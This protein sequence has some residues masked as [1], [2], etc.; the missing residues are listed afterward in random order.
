M[1][2]SVKHAT[3][4]GAGTM[5]A[6][7]A[8]H[9]ANAGI[10]VYLLDIIPPELTEKERLEGVDLKDPMVRN[11]LAR[12]GLARVM[13]SPAA[14]FS[15]PEL[16]DKVKVGN[17]EDDL[18][19]IGVSDLVIEAVVEDMEIKQALMKR[20]EVIRQS[21]SIVTTNTSGLPIKD[22]A[23]ETSDEFARH[24][25]GTH[26]FNPPP[27]M[28]LLEII[29]GPR[30]EPAVLEFM[31]GFCGEVLGKGVVVCKD[32]PNFIANRI[33]AIQRS[34]DMEYVLEEGY[35]VEE[36]DAILGRVIGRPKTAL[37]R[38]GDLVGIDVSTKV[39]KN[40]YALIPH[41]EYRELLVGPLSVDL[42]KRMIE[43]NL[44]GRKTG[45]G[46]YKRVASPEGT[47]FLGLDLAKLEY[48]EPVMQQ[49]PRLEQASNIDDL[50]ERI[51]FL[52]SED[53]RLGRLVWA[54]L[55]NVLLYSAYSTPEISDNLISVDRAMRWGYSWDLGPFELWDLLGVEAIVQRMEAED[56]TVA[57]WV[58]KMLDAGNTHFYKIENGQRWQFSPASLD[59]EI[60]QGS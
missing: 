47:Q 13:A 24:F 46:F 9:L 28:K 52:I 57:M 3:V 19:L 40:L 44:L 14:G 55:S 29:P 31:I 48:R 41:D 20:V 35:S 53:D 25:L 54:S 56:Q 8:A 42:R 58:R 18:N 26:F 15:S 59:F 34:F 43:A 32:T 45:S 39:G 17:L 12:E 16:A 37:F 7:I 5:G 10:S 22:I 60:V 49:M 1:S 38:L 30:T 51:L 11:R 4:I 36:A 21:D 6:G 27:I 2:Y 23:R 50:A 33:A